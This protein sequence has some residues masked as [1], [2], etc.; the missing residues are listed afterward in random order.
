MCSVASERADRVDAIER[1]QRRLQLRRPYST[2]VL[3]VRGLE[4][5]DDV[6]C[7]L[8]EGSA[9]SG[10]D[11]DRRSGVAFGGSSTDVASLFQGGDL[12]AGGLPGDPGSSGEGGNGHAFGIEHFDEFAVVPEHFH[13]AGDVVVVEGRAVGKTKGGGLKRPRRVGLDRSRRAGDC[14]PQLSPH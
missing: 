6:H 9:E 12:L 5:L 7:V 10:L 1:R 13:D 3:C 8:V 14:K 11:D 2:E 4:L